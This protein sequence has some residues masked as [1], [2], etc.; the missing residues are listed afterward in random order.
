MRN[1]L[2]FCLLVF[3]CILSVAFAPQALAATKK[4][5]TGNLDSQGMRDLVS[6]HLAKGEDA[7]AM[8]VLEQILG[9]SK[10][11]DLK[12]W[13]T[14]ELFRMAQTKGQ[15][16]EVTAALE[17]AARS[18]PDDLMLQKAIAEGYL[19]MRDFNQ[20]VAIYERLVK[21]HP[22]DPTLD[23]RLTDCYMLAKDFQAVIKR[24]EPILDEKELDPFNSDIL[25]NA[26]TQAGLE[27]QA[28]AL[29]QKRLA[30]EPDAPGLRA[31]Y[32]QALQDFGRLDDSVKEW[33]RVYALD[34]SN[35]MFKEKAAKVY[36]QLGNA[37]KAKEAYQYIISTAGPKQQWLKTQAETAIDEMGKK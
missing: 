2:I 23:S 26:Y 28:L 8:Q 36:Q 29:F 11:Q 13:A 33:E 21:E 6:E 37:K 30:M 10:Y 25:L 20:V 22:E 9:A 14:I 32:A 31:R 16:P 17:Q 19:R 24:L 12:E 34:P 18:N 4:A 35:L 1:R 7:D 3:S 5:T 27:P 15:L